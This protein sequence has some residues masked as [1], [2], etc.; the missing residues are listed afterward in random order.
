M[1]TSFSTIGNGVSNYTAQNLGAGKHAR[2]PE[3]YR[4]GI[5]LVWLLCVPLALLYVFCGRWLLLLFMKTPSSEAMHTGIMLL[6]ILSPFYFVVSLKLVTDGILR[7]AS[8]M[9][10]FMIATFTDLILRVI[11]AII[12]SRTALGPTGIWCAW[13]IGWTIATSVSI[14]FYRREHWNQKTGET[15]E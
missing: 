8:R 5:K 14:W 12:L 15:P 7:G 2:I 6:R 4:A 9:G 3:G 1:I 11:L 13:P 10:S